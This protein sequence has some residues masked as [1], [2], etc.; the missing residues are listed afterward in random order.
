MSIGA[1]LT[2]IGIVAVVAMAIV[3]LKSFSNDALHALIEKRRAASKIVGRAELV[4]GLERIPVALALDDSAFHYENPDLTASIELKRIDEVEYSK[5][6]STGTEVEKGEVLL[7]RSHGQAFEF[8]IGAL[9]SG[10]WHA[11]L[12]AHRLGEPAQRV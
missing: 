8:I 6:L 11:A 5:E 3:L 1:L 4:E 7:L 9:E 10:Q 12:P 2:V